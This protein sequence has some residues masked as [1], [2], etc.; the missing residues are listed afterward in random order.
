MGGGM[1]QGLNRQLATVSL[2]MS[3]DA[4]RGIATKLR[5]LFDVASAEGGGNGDGQALLVHPG[6]PRLSGEARRERTSGTPVYL[7]SHDR[8]SR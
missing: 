2:R 8:P 7:E 1:L 3:W 6:V 5:G 4:I